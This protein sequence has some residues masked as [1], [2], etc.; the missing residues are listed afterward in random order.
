MILLSS[1][2][3]REILAGFRKGSE[4]E[5][6]LDLG[7]TSGKA[8]LSGEDVV[9]PDGQSINIKYIKRIVESPGT[10][11]MVEDNEVKKL[12]FFSQETNKFYKL[13][14]THTWPAL[15]I[16]GVL[17]HRIKGT[18]P[19][20]DA[21]EKI[22]ILSP[23]SGSVLD[24]CCGLGYTAI[25]ASKTADSVVT[26]ENDKN[27]LELAKMNPF[28]QG[29]FDTGKIRIVQG[30]VSRE[31]QGFKDASF[32]LVI[33]DPPTLGLA[34]GLYSSEFYSQ[35]FRVLKPGGRLFHYTGAPG[36]RFRNVDLPTRVV[37]RL[38]KIGFTD[39]KKEKDS[40]SVVAVRP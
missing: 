24:T 3:A 23:V 7:K 19:K 21:E 37:E 4:A 32:D 17:M 16:S 14:S 11:F 35:L 12:M 26:V 28:S 15:E 8:Q 1:K 22:N 30:D 36:S 5:V 9:F 29:L 2:Q 34:G 27:V 20:R 33:H 39:L 6:S 18:D 40:L 31:I 25:L 38:R 13:H 10:V